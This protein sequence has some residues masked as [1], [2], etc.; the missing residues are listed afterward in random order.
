MSEAEHNCQDGCNSSYQPARKII[1]PKAKLPLIIDARMRDKVAFKGIVELGSLI[2]KNELFFSADPDYAEEFCKN[3]TNFAD[4]RLNLLCAIN[5]QADEFAM[6]TCFKGKTI[7]AQNT[8]KLGTDVDVNCANFA[9]LDTFCDKLQENTVSFMPVP[10]ISMLTLKSILGI[11]P[12]DYLLAKL[13]TSQ[14]SKAYQNLSDE[15][16]DL[17]YRIKEQGLTTLSDDYSAPVQQFLRVERKLY[18]QYA[19]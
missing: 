8:Y 13:Y 10:V 16:K 12:Y 4:T 2:Y 15:D 1:H 5:Q 19:H 9:G 18:L 11:L 3:A 6:Y 14:L 7:V 17:V